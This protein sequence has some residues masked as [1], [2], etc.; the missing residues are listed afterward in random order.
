MESLRGHKHLLIPLVNGNVYDES[1][2]IEEKR[3]LLDGLFSTVPAGVLNSEACDLQI[4][5]DG[6]PAVYST[7]IVRT[8][9]PPFEYSGDPETI[10]DG[11][12]VMLDPLPSGVHEIMFTGGLCDIDSGDSLFHVDVT[13]TVTV[14]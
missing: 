14:K 11:Y 9:S 5:V 2:T 7:P 4:N 12:W 10:A 13:Y 3:E 6:M 1:L 8:Q